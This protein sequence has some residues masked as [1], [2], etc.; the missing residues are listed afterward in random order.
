V[1]RGGPGLEPPATRGGLGGGEAGEGQ[2]QAQGDRAGPGPV[3]RWRRGL[4]G[5]CSSGCGG[6][7]A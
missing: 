1:E 5:R 4:T 2:R 3:A 6:C 7:S